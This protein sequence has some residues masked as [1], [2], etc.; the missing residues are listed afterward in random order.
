MESK[1]ILPWDVSMSMSW[2]LGSPNLAGE[3]VRMINPM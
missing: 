3:D 1:H 2:C